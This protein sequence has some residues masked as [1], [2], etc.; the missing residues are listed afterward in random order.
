MQAMDDSSTK[1][2]LDSAQWRTP[3]KL[4]DAIA[5]S[6]THTQAFI[7][8]NNMNKKPNQKF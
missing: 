2:L 3:N 4:Q 7:L 6:L 5:A 8:S 1:N